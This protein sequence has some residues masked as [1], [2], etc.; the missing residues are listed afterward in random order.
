MSERKPI[1]VSLF[2][3]ES[4]PQNEGYAY[5]AYYSDGHEDSEA[6]DELPEIITPSIA[7]LLYHCGK[8]AEDLGGV[9]GETNFCHQENCTT[10]EKRNGR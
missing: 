7:T 9:D 10:W 8:I 2:F 4:D 1:K 5:R 3:D 6:Y